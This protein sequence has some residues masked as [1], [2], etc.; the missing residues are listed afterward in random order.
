MKPTVENLRAR[1]IVREIDKAPRPFSRHF[2]ADGMNAKR[3]AQCIRVMMLKKGI[4]VSVRGNEVIVASQVQRKETRERNLIR[5][6][7][8]HVDDE[9]LYDEAMEVL[10]YS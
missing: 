1:E 8:L 6:M 3:L 9:R 10:G 2:P 4:V 5:K 7:M